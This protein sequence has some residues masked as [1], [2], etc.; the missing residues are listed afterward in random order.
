MCKSGKARKT[1]TDA[2]RS[3]ERLEVEGRQIA[4]L[5]DR[6]QGAVAE[7]GVQGA[8]DEAMVGEGLVLQVDGADAPVVV[9]VP[10]RAALELVGGVPLRRLEVVRPKEH[11][12][13]PVD[14]PNRHR[15]LLYERAS[16]MLEDSDPRPE[17]QNISA[18]CGFARRLAWI[19]P[20][21]P[22]GRGACRRVRA[23]PGRSRRW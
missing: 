16:P 5:G 22:C 10:A 3:K 18:A 1:V 12:L 14:R 4:V 11:A 23:A 17:G 15:L 19:T 20:S 8:D 21:C 13:V 6:H 7:P 2:L 9:Q